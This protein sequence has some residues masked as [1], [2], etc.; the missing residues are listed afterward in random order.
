M[1]AIE[2]NN[3]RKDADIFSGKFN[4]TSPVVEVF[5]AMVNGQDL[6]RFGA[7]AD[8]AVGYIKTLGERAGNGDINAAS[9]LNTLRRFVVESPIME[10]IK[11]LSIFGTY[12]NVGYDET[13]E[14]EVY[15]EAG[16]Y[17]RPQANNGDVVFPAITKEVYPVSTFTISGGYMVDYRRVA[18]G[19]M[20]RENEGMAHVR[21]DIMN[22]AKAAVVKRV[23]EAIKNAKGVKYTTENAGLTKSSVDAILTNVRR[24][25]RP[26]IVGDYAFL[27]QFTPWA[28]YIGKVDTTTVTGI[29]EKTM[30]ELAANGLLSMYNGA[31]LTEMPNPYNLYKLN[32]K[33]D[34]FETLLP[35][36]LGFVI[37]AGINSPIATWTRGGLTS[38]TANDV[39]SG[40]IVSRYDLEVAVDVA[41]GQEYKIGTIYDT[42]LGGL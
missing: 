2:L 3:V 13:I 1:N 6:S 11:L 32:A 26:T 37:P 22:Q 24:F 12:Q 28:G 17:A 16:E 38:L 5:S 31:I 36:G 14:R 34:N 20:S 39:K 25:G 23:Y 7:V 41:K 30:N 4:K 42:K 21:T 8:K 27:S 18:L 19:D 33:G 29:S 9:E 35:A 15:H 40:K 10:E